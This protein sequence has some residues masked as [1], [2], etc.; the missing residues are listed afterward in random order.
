MACVQVQLDPAAQV[1]SPRARATQGVRD[2]LTSA[3]KC[4]RAEETVG[5]GQTR[6][7]V[8]SKGPVLSSLAR[9]PGSA[10]SSDPPAALQHVCGVPVQVTATTNL[11][12]PLKNLSLHFIFN[13]PLFHAFKFFAKSP[14]KPFL[15]S[16]PSIY[17]S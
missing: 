16:S 13:L 12:A 3:R 6:R 11:P 2:L 4:A 1:M 15:G 5:L 9:L 7:L 14:T 10:L 8:P 17:K